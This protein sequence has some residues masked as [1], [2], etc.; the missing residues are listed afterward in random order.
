MRNKAR[1]KYQGEPL[2][3]D[4]RADGG[5]VVGPGSVHPNGHLYV[6]AGAGWAW[7]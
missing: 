2:E 6:R 3:I 1:I 7:R 5:Y 4:I